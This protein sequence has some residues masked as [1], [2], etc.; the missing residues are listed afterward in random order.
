MELGLGM[1]GWDPDVFWNATL[2]EIEAAAHGLARMH[3]EGEDDDTNVPQTP[4]LSGE[5]E[6][7]KEKLGDGS[8]A[9]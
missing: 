5:F 2:G 6:A 7:L 4:M 9:R 8:K 1:L 3:G